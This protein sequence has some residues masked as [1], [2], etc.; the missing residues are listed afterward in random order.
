ML[1]RRDFM[2]GAVAGA[3]I[4]LAGVIVGWLIGGR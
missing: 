4:A 1:N 3:G 2:A